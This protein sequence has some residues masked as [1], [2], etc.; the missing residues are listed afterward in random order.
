M[1]GLQHVVVVG[2][3]RNVG[4]HIAVTGVH[5]QCHP[6]AAFEHALVNGHALIKNRLESSARE[7]SLE[8]RFDLRFP[9]GA[10]GVILQLGEQSFN[11]L[12][13]ALPQIT[14]IA[15]HSQSL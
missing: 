1:G 14:D 2:V 13:P 7:N 4:V 9:A 11:P 3:D 12:Q 15:H 8:R 5:V 6:H 10:Q